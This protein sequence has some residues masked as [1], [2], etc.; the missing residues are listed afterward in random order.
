MHESPASDSL[1]S[2]NPFATRC[3]RPGAIPFEFLAPMTIA[4]LVARFRSYGWRAQIVGPHGSG[5]STLLAWLQPDLEAAGRDVCAFTLHNGQRHL[6]VTT[7]Q[8]SSW[9]ACTIV[10]VDGHEQLSWLAQWRLRWWCHQCR[11]GLLITRHRPCGFMSGG[12]LPVLW[13]TTTSPELLGRLVDQLMTSWSADS[14][15]TA[16][17][18]QH[19][20]DQHHGNLREALLQLYDVYASRQKGAPRSQ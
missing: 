19:A 2:N 16:E 11:C 17:Q 9:D 6:P 13:Q 20:F 4:R 1:E 12:W 10:V 3:I 8:R 7:G 14:Q 15:P 5:K 18:V